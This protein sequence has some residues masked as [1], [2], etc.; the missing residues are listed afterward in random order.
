[1]ELKAG[2]S[3]LALQT[4]GAE[5]EGVKVVVKANTQLALGGNIMVQIQGGI[6]KIN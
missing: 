6:V 3:E 1:M 2:A 5:L 4:A